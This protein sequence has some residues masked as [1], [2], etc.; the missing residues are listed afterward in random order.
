MRVLI[1]QILTLSITI[2]VV[3]GLRI[4]TSQATEPVADLANTIQSTVSAAADVESAAAGTQT[5]VSS[6]ITS[7]LTGSLEMKELSLDFIAWELVNVALEQMLQSTTEWVNSGFDGNP[8][9]VVDFGNYMERVGAKFAESYIWNLDPNGPLGGLCQPFSLSIRAALQIQYEDLRN[10]DGKGRKVRGCQIDD[11]VANVENMFADVERQVDRLQ[12]P[13]NPWQ[14]WFTMTQIPENNQHGAFLQAQTAFGI[15]LKTAQGEEEVTLGW[16]NGYFAPKDEEGNA[17][18]PGALIQDRINSTFSISE[19]RLTIADEL[20]EV[21]GAL[22]QQ[23]AMQVMSGQ[24]GLRGMTDSGYG[25]GNYYQ[26]VANDR[27]S[28][29][30]I[31]AQSATYEQ[32]RVLESR[33]RDAQQQVITLID[34]AAATC[35]GLTPSLRDKR[36]NAITQVASSTALIAKLVEF[37]Q[38]ETTLKSL[39]TS[40]STEAQT[41][42][43]KYNATSIP[44]ALARLAERYMQYRAARLLH[45]EQEVAQLESTLLGD[46]GDTYPVWKAKKQFNLRSEILFF[47]SDDPE[48]SRVIERCMG[49]SAGPTGPIPP[50]DFNNFDPNM[51]NIF[52]P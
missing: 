46:P 6:G 47:T 25:G 27:N 39:T 9:F 48:T 20:N 34:G 14:N 18:T 33:Y 44:Q 11:V 51:F 15:S 28:A 43:T 45:S 24:G 17:T 5:A 35:G 32:S 49:I 37:A 12:N 7:F 40:T 42:F 23:L 22:M 38:D 1:Q 30:A 3:F 41:L 21:L 4:H 19:N 26:R 52:G 16:A 8:A 50:F 2:T 29:S 36:E 10:N 13:Q 31:N